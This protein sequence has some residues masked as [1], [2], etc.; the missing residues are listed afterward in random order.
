MAVEPRQF[1]TMTPLAKTGGEGIEL[2]TLGRLG[3]SDQRRR[4]GSL[5]A[6]FSGLRRPQ[7]S[8]ARTESAVGGG[9][10]LW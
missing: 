2:S 4:R 1:G 8:S 9:S 6:V 5:A 7:D 10:L 3:L